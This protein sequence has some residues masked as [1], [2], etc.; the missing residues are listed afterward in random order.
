VGG[1]GIRARQEGSMP[2]DT[3]W[4]CRPC[5]GRTRTTAKAWP[6]DKEE[7]YLTYL[8]L[9]GLYL[10]LS[11]RGSEV[12]CPTQRNSYILSLGFMSYLG[13][14]FLH[15]FLEN[16]ISECEEAFMVALISFL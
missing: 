14:D 4:H 5:V 16:L 2:A 13:L 10:S 6:C 9:R 3:W 12:I 8:P 15:H 11:S 1:D 7:C